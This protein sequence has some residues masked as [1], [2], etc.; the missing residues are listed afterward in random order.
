MRERWSV[1]Q[2][3][4]EGGHFYLFGVLELLD[5]RDE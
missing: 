1:I 3:G 2:E 5:G 4:R